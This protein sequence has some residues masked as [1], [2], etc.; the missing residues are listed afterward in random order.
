MAAGFTT[1]NLPSRLLGVFQHDLYRLYYH[2]DVF[3]VT[4]VVEL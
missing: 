1:V 4:E 3:W 2:A